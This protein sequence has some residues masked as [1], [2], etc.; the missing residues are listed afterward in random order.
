MKVFFGTALSLCLLATSALAAKLPTT[1]VRGEYLEARTADVYTGPCF[2]NGEVG[3]TG[4]LAVMGWHIDKGEFEGV[5]LNGLSVVGVIRSKNTLGDFTNTSNAAK[6]V[7]IVDQSATPE[8]QLALKAFA[9]KMGGDLL[10]DVVRTEIQPIN[11]AMKDNNVHSREAEMTAGGLAKIA[12]RPL[13]DSDQI[14]HNEG[15]WY[16]PLTKVDHA[17][18]AYTT[19]NSYAGQGLGETWSYPEKRSSFVATFSLDN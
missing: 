1:S 15:V 10:S 8:Q 12:T 11:F 19:S 14:C 6:A 16:A 18:A 9:Q 3:Q 13:V 2:A 5:N 17:M 7:I 4:R